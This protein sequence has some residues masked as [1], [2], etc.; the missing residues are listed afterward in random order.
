MLKNKMAWFSE[1]IKDHDVQN[2][3]KAMYALKIT[4]KGMHEFVKDEL[5][6]VHKVIYTESTK[7]LPEG[8]NCK[9]CSTKTLKEKEKK[10]CPN[11]ICHNVRQEIIQQHRHSNPSWINTNADQW[12]E[13]SWEI[14]K[15]FL[16]RSGY[17]DKSSI[18]ECDFNGVCSVLS[19]CKHFEGKLSFD[20]SKKPNIL[21]EILDIVNDDM[22]HSASLKVTNAQL[23]VLLDKLRMLLR[24]SKE[25]ANRDEAKKAIEELDNVQKDDFIPS[26]EE[27]ESILKEDLRLRLASHYRDNLA[28]MP[29]SPI[30]PDRDAN[31]SM[32]YVTPQIVEKN[33][34]TPE[35]AGKIVTRYEDVFGTE[36]KKNNIFLVGEPGRGK[37]TF[38]ANCA[39]E[40]SRRH[41]RMDTKETMRDTTSFIDTDYFENVEFIF[42]IKLRDACEFCDLNE[43]IKDQVIAQIYQP[44]DVDTG[45]AIA[46][47]VL[48]SNNCIII[49]DGLDEWNHPKDSRCRCRSDE[50]GI[51]PF[52]N[53][54]IKANVLIT[55]RPWRLSQHRVKDSKIHKY[56]D[57]NGVRDYHELVKSVLSVMNGETGTKRSE[58]FF[59]YVSQLHIYHLLYVPIISMQLV[60]MWF[61]GLTFSG[62]LCDIYAAMIDMLFGRCCG[63]S[64][65]LIQL[66]ENKMPDCF[67]NKENVMNKHPVF[68]KLCRLAFFTLFSREDKSAVV[69]EETTVKKEMLEDDKIVSLKSGIL[70]ERKS[71]SYGRKSSHFSFIHKTFQEFLAAVHL[72]LNEDEYEKTVKSRY[73]GDAGGNVL[74]ISQVFIFICGIKPDLAIQMSSWIGERISKTSLKISWMNRYEYEISRPDDSTIV[75]LQ[76]MI[77]SGYREAQNNN[78]GDIPLTLTNFLILRDTD[79]DSIFKQ[80]IRIN[81][82]RVQSLCITD[83]NCAISEEELQEVFTSSS[84]SLTSVELNY[85]IGQYDL[86]LCHRLNHLEIMGNITTSVNVDTT[87][88]TKCELN[89]V[90]RNVEYN[91]M[92]SLNCYDRVSKLQYL[93]FFCVRYTKILC[94][95]L[96]RLAQLQY[97][98]IHGAD[99]RELHFLPPDSITRIKLV[100]VTMTAE[101]LR[102][103]VKLMEKITHTVKCL[104]HSCYL[105]PVSDVKKIRR[106]V[107]DSNVFTLETYE[108]K[109][110]LKEKFKRL[111]FVFK[112]DAK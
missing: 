101:A 34:R 6:C 89:S 106:Y 20:I 19:N 100:D 29:I 76:S 82:C 96:P 41:V 18:E 42:H 111:N 57:I 28:D 99:L 85:S 65:T 94:K 16:P 68:I 69:F 55:T 81:K 2:W 33:H 91:I 46:Q 43:I 78:H 49:E 58:D 97:I 32:F 31:L 35:I 15:C 50:K 39:L 108:R 53:S 88:L 56:L 93:S 25:L 73:I 38:S 4:K 105:K 64:V 14:G 77:L 13:S 51:L 23:K 60:C 30:L 24:D 71:N 8:S 3:I 66:D 95:T 112:S 59:T 92:R 12:W 109:R 75:S 107:Q 86:S 52:R 26:S 10:Q 21:T 9:D 36:F 90:S 104:L 11:N 110:E 74:D 72:F 63:L 22:R 62:S 70:T 54:A 40:W 84:D 67:S 7:G 83:G 98:Y 80:L 44:N 48:E 47:K 37:S 45:Y 17:M 103:L 87:N 1:F 102:K 79:K 61:D 27:T 5:R